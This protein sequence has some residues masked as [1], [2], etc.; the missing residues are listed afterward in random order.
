MCR[1]SLSLCCP[2]KKKKKKNVHVANYQHTDH[3]IY[4]YIDS[5]P[6]FVAYICIHTVCYNSYHQCSDMRIH[7]FNKTFT[8]LLLRLTFTSM[9]ISSRKTL[10]LLI[11]STGIYRMIVYSRCKTE[12]Y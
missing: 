12:Y 4:S 7:F 11:N 9:Q 3:C 6:S 8:S 1:F 2:W 10:A 5:V